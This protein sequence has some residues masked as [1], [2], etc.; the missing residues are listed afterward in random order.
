[1][2]ENDGI[3][4]HFEIIAQFWKPDAQRLFTNFKAESEQVAEDYYFNSF[5]TSSMR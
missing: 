3:H 4:R 2:V 5:S 1:M